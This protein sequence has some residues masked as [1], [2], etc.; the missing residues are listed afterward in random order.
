MTENNL[1]LTPLKK[2]LKSLHNAIN[3]P[4][5]EYTRDATIQR[6]E[7][8]FELSWKILKRHISMETGINEYTIKNIFRTAAKQG[9]ITHV[10]AWFDYLKA[11]NL[12][13]H[14]YN[15]LTADETYAFAKQFVND[16]DYLIAQL[17]KIYGNTDQP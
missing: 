11:R 14:T 1:V 17:E 3:Q 9:L 4:F 13:S 15:E 5:N 8:T 10:D 2:A 12:T 6:F 7:Y 16:A